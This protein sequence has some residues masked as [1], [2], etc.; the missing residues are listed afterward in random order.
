VIEKV[1]SARNQKDVDGAFALWSRKSPELAEQKLALQQQFAIEDSS[2]TTLRGVRLF[3][4]LRLKHDL[5]SG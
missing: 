4:I 3:C 1:I 2:F 5:S